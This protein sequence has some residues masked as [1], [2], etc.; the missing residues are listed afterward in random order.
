MAEGLSALR[1][2]VKKEDGLRY[3]EPP[4]WSIPVRHAL[5]AF[6]LKAKQPV[7]AE[8]VYREDLQRWP[9]NGW[10]LFGLTQALEQQGKT[11]EAKEIKRRFEKVWQRADVTLRSSCF[12]QSE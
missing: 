5:G 10:S 11:A 4:D 12:C 3:D 1:R 7:E 6:L 2:A 9:E 8:Q